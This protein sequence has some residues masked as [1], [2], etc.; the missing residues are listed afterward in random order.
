[1]AVPGSQ[2]LTD[3]ARPQQHLSSF[4]TGHIPAALEWLDRLHALAGD[5]EET[6]AHF[7]ECVA[8]LC[9]Q[10]TKAKSAKTAIQRV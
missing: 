4:S 7:E 8:S 3:M 5:D 6:E 9:A 1:M 10:D 2:M